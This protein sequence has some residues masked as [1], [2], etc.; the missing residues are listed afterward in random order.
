M[1]YKTI[2][3]LVCLMLAVMA[4][5][6]GARVWGD[7]Y[8]YQGQANF[9]VS[10]VVSAVDI[11]RDR[12]AL[13]ADGG[14]AYTLDTYK[15][16]IALR[17]TDKPGMTVDIVP[18]MRLRARGT[19]V[20]ADIVEAD[21]VTVLPY[22]GGARPP[23][24]QRDSTPTP[25]GQ[26]ILLRGTVESVDSKRDAVV[27]RVNDHTRTVLVDERTDFQDIEYGGG[28]DRIPLKPGDRV[29]VAGTFARDG[30]VL[31][32]AVTRRAALLTGEAANH[33]GVLTGP[34]TH[35]SNHLTSRDI[36]VRVSV[37]QEVT[38]HVP[39]DTAIM[40]DGRPISV[41]SLSRNDVVRVEGTPDGDDFKAS[42]IVV[43]RSNDDGL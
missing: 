39:R 23:E 15:A 7:G 10:G 18:G 22:V 34:V 30:T 37:G 19:R 16:A 8:P 35:P 33:R 41:H 13:T 2:V 12:I 5:T 43:L 31:A 40:R 32:S 38:V 21:R 42:R 26:S 36:K 20:S 4:G 27:V 17:G 28:S 14:H 11:D 9:V 1:Q 29:T 24:P 3:G 25:A 6:G